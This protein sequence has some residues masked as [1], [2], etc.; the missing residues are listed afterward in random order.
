MAKELSY[1]VFK[2]VI[3]KN[4]RKLVTEDTVNEINKLTLDPEYGEEFKTSLISATNLLAGKEKWSLKQYIDAVKFYS[5]TA[6]A[7]TQ[8]DAYV[9]VFPDRLQARLDRGETK[10]DMNGE[11]SRFNSSELVNRVRN[12]ALVP[13]H[14][15]NQ[16][17]VQLAINTLAHL[18]VNARSEVAKVSAATAL[19]KELRPPDAQKIELDIGI[20]AT[21][22]IAELR[23]ATEELVIAQRQSIEAGMAVKY[24][25]E[26]RVVDVEVDYE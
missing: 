19:L 14:L 15:V 23:K 3:P 17:T 5:L 2:E 6:A 12:Q 22:S 10:N 26:S 4:M 9:K 1:E 11:A 20:K 24:I 7:M 16:G 21:D 18:M 25:A 13:L 8:T